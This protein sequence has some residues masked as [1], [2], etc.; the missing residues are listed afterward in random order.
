MLS[1]K[2]GNGGGGIAAEGPTRVIGSQIEDNSAG[3]AVGGGLFDVGTVRR[4]TI[5]GNSAAVG[6]GVEAFPSLR[7]MITGST[8]AGNHAG[9][10]GGAIDE[11]GTVIVRR[12]IISGN[13]AGGPFQGQG[14]AVEVNGGAALQLANSTIAGN[15][16]RAPGGAAIDNFGGSVTLSFDTFSANTGVISGGG[17]NSATATIL[18][19]GGATPNCASPLHETVGFNL[20]TDTSCGLSL[21]TDLITAHPLLGP[22]ADNGGRTKTVALLRG[23]PAVNAGGLPATSGCPLTDQRGQTRPWGPACDIGAFE[24]HYRP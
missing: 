18:A 3:T 5:S 17:F 24:L 8:L 6:G 10:N 22:L 12:S 13:V 19:S 23:S 2:C 16:T 11:S 21:S 1:N 4:S 20:A 7:M 9:A 14:P 15:S